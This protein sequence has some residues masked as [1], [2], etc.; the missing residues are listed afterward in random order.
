MNPRLRTLPDLVFT[1][2]ASERC[3]RVTISIPSLALRLEARSFILGNKDGSLD[4]RFEYKGCGRGMGDSED[5]NCTGTLGARRGTV[6]G[7]E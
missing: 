5:E 2:E 7:E 1:M 3:R 6:F 4:T